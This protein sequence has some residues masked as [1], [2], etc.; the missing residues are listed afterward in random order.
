MSKKFIWTPTIYS[1]LIIILDWPIGDTVRC[2]GNLNKQT[3]QLKIQTIRTINFEEEMTMI[4]RLEAISG[5][6]LTKSPIKMK[7]T[8]MKWLYY[9]YSRENKQDSCKFDL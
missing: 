8:T 4:K 2:V 5:F 7:W 9:F 1:D 3:G 6:A